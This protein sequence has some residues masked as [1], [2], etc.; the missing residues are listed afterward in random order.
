MRRAVHEIMRFWLNRGIDG[1]RLDVINFIS[2]EQS[3]PDS[4]NG[5]VAGSEYYAAGPRLHEYLKE[6]GAILREYNAFSV[7]EMPCVYDLKEII[8]SVGFDRGELD[9]IF[10]FEL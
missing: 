10:H 4:F 5:V 9:M 1:F 3:Y 7:G 8:K 2:K 6:I